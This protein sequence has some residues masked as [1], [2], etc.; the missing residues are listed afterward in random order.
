[1]Y[2]ALTKREGLGLHLPKP[3]VQH[4]R[5]YLTGKDIPGLKEKTASPLLRDCWNKIV[6]AAAFSTDGYL[7]LTGQT[8]N[9]NIAVSNAIEAKALMYVLNKQADLGRDAVDAVLHYYATL[10][11]SPDRPDVTREVGRAIV[12]GSM[13]YDW[14][15]D[16]LTDAEKTTL[17]GRMETLATAME[18]GWPQIKGS[19]LTGHTVEAQLSRDMLSLA[20]A[21]YNE[22]PNIYNRVAGRIFAEFVPARRFYYPAGYHHQGSA[23]GAYRFSWEMYA[24]F[25]FDRMGYP[26]L[27]GKEQ[28]KVPYYFIYARRPDGQLLRNGDDYNEHSH[29]FG[30][31]WQLGQSAMFLAGS[32]HNDPVM[33]AEALKERTIGESRDYLFEFL[34]SNKKAISAANKTSLPLTNY[35]APPFGAMI[36][37]TGWEDGLKSPSVVAE[38]KVQ[39]YNF[40]NHQHLDAGSFQLYYK[41]PMAVQSG[42]YQGI[43]GTYGDEHF[44]NYAQRSIAHNTLLV[45]DPNEKFTWHSKAVRNDGG[46]RYPNDAHEPD[47]L[48]EVIGRGYKTG[49]VL[50][51]AVGPDPVKP[52]FSYL[53][54]EL[55]EAYSDKVKSFKR[56]F[57]FLNFNEPAIPAALIVFDQVSVS[58]PDF[59]KYW[60]LHTVEEPMI[61]GIRTTVKRTGRG[62]GGKMINTTLL[63]MANDLTIDK[64]GGPG[65]EYDVF[66][67]NY[68]QAVNP[69]TSSADSTVWRI[70]VRPKKSAAE[71][72]F[73]NVMQVMDIHNTSPVDK[74]P[75]LVETE[76]F[77]GTRIGDRVVL[78]SKNGRLVGEQFHLKITGKGVVK[79]L[80]ADVQEG[81]WKV[82]SKNSNNQIKSVSQV[83]YLT[84]DAGDYTFSRK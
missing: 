34:F 49:Q 6:D 60:L 52:E 77:I 79:V 55:A 23:Y 68:P 41:G 1:M 37:R 40:V 10:K 35:F 82:S 5:L 51:H 54:G 69:S 20:I 19:S 26:D 78:F 64:I 18:I 50:A 72:S 65:K 36:A 76:E 38:M 59:R 73:L 43:N 9:N 57:V 80:I 53:K 29:R 44:K 16:L 27:Y 48:N 75:K 81:D 11:I 14:C 24:T 17:I 62:Y 4:P 66:G 61:E 31:W 8:H 21:T 13:V 45:Y 22:N 7:P 30:K 74:L 46:Q 32:Y 58:D 3:P 33:L 83:L 42:V 84:L 71:N 56:S 15:Y 39:T 2:P 12:T 67:V 28:K 25:I 47:T 70:Q 63:P